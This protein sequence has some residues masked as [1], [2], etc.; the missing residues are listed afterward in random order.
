M[1]DTAATPATPFPTLPGKPDHAAIE[2]HILDVWERDDTFNQLRARNT[3]GPIFSFLDGPITANNSMGVHHAWG[4]TLKDVFQRWYGLR[5]YDQRYQN[6]FDCQGL[7][8]EVE[9][10][11]ALNLNSKKEIE[12]YGI[13]KFSAACRD[14]VAEYSEV[15]TRQSQRLG[16]WMDWDNDY[17]TLSDT[18]ISYI[19]KF[20]QK[21]N[22]KG[23]LYVGHRP[24]TWCPRCGTSLSQ[25]EM[26]DSYKDVV[27]PSLH[28]AFPL[29]EREGEAVVVWTTTPWTLPA[30]VAAAVNPT[31]TYALVE[32]EGFNLW[33]GQGR[34]EAVFGEDAV[35]LDTKP[36]SE[37]VGWRYRGPFAHLPASAGGED[38]CVPGN[39]AA[40]EA[41][42]LQRDDVWRVLG[43]EEVSLEDGTGI[44]HIAPGCGQ[45]DYDLG[46]E[47]GLPSIIPVDEAGIFFEGFGELTGLTTHEAKD[48]VIGDLK[49]Q[50]L[51]V[52]SGSLEHRYPSCWRCQT[53]LIF[54]LVDEWFIS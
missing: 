23:W 13:D 5:G 2:N 17:Y 50:G 53:E 8:V 22:D 47:E 14:R 36:G 51:L 6:G 44:V 25:H 43:W 38:P 34:V 54:R 42:K 46:Q 31:A 35:V 4:R 29:L 21:C 1:T 52:R 26:L 24:M 39:R 20:L 7:W 41:A 48:V 18:N 40:R 9:V 15:Q 33:M 45:E 12:S 27:H 11:K 32:R 19:W 49:Q 37:L 16:Q 28:V 3:G 10:E 30:N